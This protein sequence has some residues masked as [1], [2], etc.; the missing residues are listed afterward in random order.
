MTSF[1]QRLKV[2]FNGLNFRPW[3]IISFFCLILF[4]INLRISIF[5][6]D[7]IFFK[8]ALN[9]RTIFHYLKIRYMGWTGRMPVEFLLV[10][11]ISHRLIIWK[12]LNTIVCSLL[13]VS[14]LRYV[15]SYNDKLSNTQKTFLYIFACSIFA[16]LNICVISTSSFWITGSF[17]Y[18]WTTVAAI[19]VMIPY[20][21]A[22]FGEKCSKLT[23]IVGFIASLYA[24]YFEQTSVVILA[25]LS[26]TLVYL[27]FKKIKINIGLILIYISTIIN[28]IILFKAPGNY[29]RLIRETSNWMPEFAHYSIITKLSK[30]ALWSLN[31][32][33]NENQILMFLLTSILAYLIYKNKKGLK[34]FIVSLIP[35]LYFS[36]KLLPFDSI[37]G[38][39]TQFNLQNFNDNYLFNIIGKEYHGLFK[40]IA[41]T[42]LILVLFI[43]LI[44]IFI[45]FKDRKKSLNLSVLF[46]ASN[47][48]Y[49]MI[50]FSPTIYASGHRIF[51]VG[52]VLLY[53]VLVSLYKE[54][55]MS[56]I[57]HKKILILLNIILFVISILTL[58][59]YFLLFSKG[60]YY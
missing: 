1:I 21:K 41:P 18:L 13:I 38:H 37:F 6:G 40:H 2:K 4:S 30:G 22:F 7:D 57:K 36:I 35:I 19:F 16:L 20:K 34:T 5:P 27:L 14:I 10:I 17:V 49:L 32:I 31:H 11:L 47:L 9:T 53:I 55:L 45:L 39:M 58:A 52:D 33:V 56:D 8:N 46:I 60:I 3:F 54:V 15:K 26:L 12:I 48:S 44:E 59:N 29:V 50:G 43:I 24:S 25:Y 23:Y 51:F 42:I 28:S